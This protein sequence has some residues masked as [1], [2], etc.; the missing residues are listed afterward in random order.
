[1]IGE[2]AMVDVLD[3]G[4]VALRCLA[5]PSGVGKDRDPAN[6]ARM[7]FDAMGTRTEEEDLKLCEYL[8]KNK[9][10][11]PFEM[12]ELWIEMKLPI[13]V[14]RQFVR[15]RTVSINEMSARYVTLPAQW[16]IPDP[17]IVG[18]KPDKAKQGRTAIA[19][20]ENTQWFVTTLGHTCAQDYENY[21]IAI[22]RGIPPEL[23]RCLLHLNHYTHWLWKQ[24]LHNIM[25][26]LS[27]RDH[28]HAQWEA[29]QYALAIDTLIRAHLPHT[30]G[31]YDKYRRLEER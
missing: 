4:Y 27:L 30:M 22:K 23:A 26:F 5:G 2:L 19:P 16:Y 12:V 29:Q 25:H 14:A 24:D 3:H 9:H 15:H 13:F 10:T 7:S 8:M 17:E 18:I 6:A 28:S 1:M 11:T 21:T 20:S 31:L